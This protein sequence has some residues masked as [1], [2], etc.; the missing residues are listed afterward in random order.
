MIRRRTSGGRPARERMMDR[1]I[2]QEHARHTAV[3]GKPAV[4]SFGKFKSIPVTE[5]DTGYLIWCTENMARCPVYVVAE[6]QRRGLGAAVSGIAHLTKKQRKRAARKAERADAQRQA[7][8]AMLSSLQAGVV[9]EGEDY[10][11]LRDE[12]ELAGGVDTDCPFGED[13]CGPTVCWSG[14]KPVVVMSEFSRE[15]TWNKFAP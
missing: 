6:L 4:M 3:A 10:Q 12:W 11:R 5:V 1:R 14:G 8:Q 9:T 13:Y 2:E 15:I 7:S